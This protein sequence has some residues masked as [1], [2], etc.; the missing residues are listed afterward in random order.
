M[1]KWKIM[2]IIAIVIM[3]ACILICLLGISSVAFR[4][5]IRYPMDFLGVS[6]WNKTEHIKMLLGLDLYILGVP[7]LIGILLFIWCF[8]RISRLNKD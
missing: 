2:R 1:K 5:D 6:V 4:N 8:I 7:F 3:V